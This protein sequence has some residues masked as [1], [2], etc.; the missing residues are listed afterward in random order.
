MQS[1]KYSPHLSQSLPNIRPSDNTTTRSCRC[2]QGQENGNRQIPLRFGGVELPGDDQFASDQFRARTCPLPATR[3]SGLPSPS[4]SAEPRRDGTSSE[5]TLLRMEESLH[6]SL[7]LPSPWL[8]RTKDGSRSERTSRSMDSSPSMRQ[9][10][11]RMVLGG[12]PIRLGE[13]S[14]DFRP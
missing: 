10:K 6:D 9:G 11:P 13:Q 14:K 8:R 4:K 3:S 5:S 1:G 7:N 12:N 2:H